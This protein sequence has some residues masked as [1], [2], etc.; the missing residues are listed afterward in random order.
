MA[1]QHVRRASVSP[2]TVAAASSH[3]QP[4]DEPLPLDTQEKSATVT[5]LNQPAAPEAKAPAN[6]APATVTD[7]EGAKKSQAVKLED[8]PFGEIKTTAPDTFKRGNRA[9]PEDHPLVQAYRQSYEKKVGIDVETTEPDALTKIIRRIA[10]QE[11]KGVSVKRP[12]D[13]VV[14]FLAQDR[15][16]VVRKKPAGE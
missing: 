1:T 4:Y 14:S 8:V 5:K 16:K 2:A 3:R 13:G 9:I 7:T 10:N 6:A 11:G 15:K 12:R